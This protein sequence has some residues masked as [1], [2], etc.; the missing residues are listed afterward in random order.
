MFYIFFYMRAT[1]QKRSCDN[2]YFF[3]NI[4]P[5]KLD[6]FLF[7]QIADG[8]YL[9]VEELL[10]VGYITV[11]ESAIAISNWLQNIEIRKDDKN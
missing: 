11:L 6:L 4:N 3:L 5:F 10:T 9:Y 2:K 8:A 1:Y 7:S